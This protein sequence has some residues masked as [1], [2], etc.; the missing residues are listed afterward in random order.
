MKNFYFSVISALAIAGAAH[1]APVSFGDLTLNGDATTSGT[2]LDLTQNSN[3]QKGSAFTDAVAIDANTR[4]TAF[5]E[6][7][8]F[9]NGGF[10]PG[11][12]DGIVFAVQNST[13]GV[14]ALGGGGAG[15][16]YQGIGNSI[17]V[18]LDTWNNGSIDG[19]SDNH[20]G[21]NLNGSINSAERSIAP[22]NLQTENNPGFVWVEYNG[23]QL[24]VFIN[25]S[26]T[27]PMTALLSRDFDLT[28]LGSEVHFGFTAS[29]GAANAVHRINS[30]DLTVST[31]APV[32]LPA[33]LPLLAAGLVG[34]GLIRRNKS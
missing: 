24:D 11:G 22:F 32:P 13:S 14:N 31:A 23:T 2:A 18:E 34:F 25:N 12:A 5:F 6:F 16:G 3:S 20:V 7:D 33:G 19:N 21:I 27:Q 30:F 1:A 26:N 17:A 8:I 4:F 9:N 28:S 15:I 29:T 10:S